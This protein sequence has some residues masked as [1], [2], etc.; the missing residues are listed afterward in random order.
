[1]ED[2]LKKKDRLDQEWAA[3]CGYEADPCSTA[4]AEKVR[5]IMNL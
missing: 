5:N 4:I 2:H 3:L 1:M